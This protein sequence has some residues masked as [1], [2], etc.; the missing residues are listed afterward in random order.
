MLFSICLSVVVL[1]LVGFAVL[2]RAAFTAPHAVED[3]RGFQLV[4]VSED[5][6]TPTMPAVSVTAPDLAFFH[7]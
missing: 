5:Q 4:A 7:R 1:T 2:I 6:P 3:E